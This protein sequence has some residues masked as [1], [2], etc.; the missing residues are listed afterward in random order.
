MRHNQ[1]G[2]SQLRKHQTPTGVKPMVYNDD[3]DDGVS[4]RAQIHE[5]CLKIC[6]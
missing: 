4:I 1:N 5:H 6:L 2:T 3:D